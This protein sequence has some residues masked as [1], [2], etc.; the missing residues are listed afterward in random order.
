MNNE[1]DNAS[2]SSLPTTRI[3]TIR[4]SPPVAQ[5]ISSPLSITH[6]ES[7]F[8]LV[9]DHHSIENMGNDSPSKADILLGQDEVTNKSTLKRVNSCDT[10]RPT[11]AQR[12]HGDPG[13]YEGE[14]DDTEEEDED[15]DPAAKI[16][17]F[18]W[19]DLMQR[20][21]DAM[22]NCHDEEGQ[23]AQEWE[24]LMNVFTCLP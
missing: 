13:H 12:A 14:S 5:D 23:L 16:V 19:D 6:T 2:E 9:Q 21:H 18:D 3:Q 7:Q 10:E 24:S 22:Q 4:S 20:Y 15:S 8:S 1:T 11:S 17:D